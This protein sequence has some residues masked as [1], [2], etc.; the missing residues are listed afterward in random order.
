MRPSLTIDHG[1]SGATKLVELAKRLRTH[2][3]RMTSSARSSHIGSCLSA[4]DI[5]A[6]LYGGVLRIDPTRPDWADRDRLC[7]VGRSGL[8]RRRGAADV[9]PKR[10]TAVRPCD[11]RRTGDRA[12][13]GFAGP[14]P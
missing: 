11:H 10:R 6:V 7:G 8:F 9:R 12:L 1:A 14:R 5:L 4:A 13:Y 2:A 3:L